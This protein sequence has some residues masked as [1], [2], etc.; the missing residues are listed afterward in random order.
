MVPQGTSNDKIITLQ[1]RFRETFVVSSHNTAGRSRIT[2]R[3]SVT[4]HT[5]ADLLHFVESLELRPLLSGAYELTLD[6]PTRVVSSSTEGS[7]TLEEMNIT[8]DSV[9]WVTFSA[10]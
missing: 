8:T 10:D 9:V 4:R 7:K 3:F 5:A 6:Y 1:F 2:R